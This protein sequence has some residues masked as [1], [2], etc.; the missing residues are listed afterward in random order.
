MEGGPEVLLVRNV[1]FLRPIIILDK[2]GERK[3][4]RRFSYS[5]NCRKTLKAW[6]ECYEKGQQ[7]N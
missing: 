7:L 3:R 6:M 5:L 1:L 2:Y 4:E